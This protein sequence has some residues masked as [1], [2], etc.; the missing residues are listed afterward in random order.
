MP[1]AP[2]PPRT[3]A[4]IATAVYGPNNQGLG[5]G[6]QRITET[7]IGSLSA[8]VLEVGYELHGGRNR[9]VRPHVINLGYDFNIGGRLNSWLGLYGGIGLFF[10]VYTY[11]GQKNVI[12]Q[13]EDY[14]SSLNAGMQLYLGRLIIGGGA[15]YYLAY[16]YGPDFSGSD[17]DAFLNVWNVNAH[18]GWRF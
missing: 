3:S 14:S 4:I 13:N 6:F 18:C 7:F 15:S 10:P 5:L 11:P 12:Q 2:E 1:A 17:Q 9:P 8:Y 16:I